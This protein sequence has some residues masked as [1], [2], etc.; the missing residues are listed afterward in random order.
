[1]WV[2]KNREAVFVRVLVSQVH[3]NIREIKTER[4][5]VLKAIS[6]DIESNF[7]RQES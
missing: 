2:Y 3:R 7:V 5:P 6:V 4:S 1:M